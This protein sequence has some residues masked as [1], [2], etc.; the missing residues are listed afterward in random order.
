MI[1][2][3]RLTGWSESVSEPDAALLDVAQQYS[4]R[5]AWAGPSTLVADLH[6]LERLFGDP[7]S[8]GEALRSSLADRGLQVHVALASTCTAARLVAAA[9]AGL[10][11]VPP[12]EQADLLSALP[13]DLLQT[14]T[15]SAAG[16]TRDATDS[17]PARFYRMSPVSDILRARR[18]ARTVTRNE[19]PADV[20]TPERLETF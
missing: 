19:T 17:P 13:I 7:R 1:G 9:R 2:C 18:R 4:P 6:G 14:L 16:S 8:L 5:V 20:L 3:L 11:V 10:T 15:L 12:A